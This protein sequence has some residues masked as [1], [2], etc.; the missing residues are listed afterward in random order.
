MNIRLA[1][2]FVVLPI[3]A[4]GLMPAHAQ[5]EQSTEENESS[6]DGSFG[7]LEDNLRY[8]SLM[9][10]IDGIGAN[11]GASSVCFPGMTT[12]MIDEKITEAGKADIAV[13]HLA[14][15]LV[16]ISGECS[17]DSDSNY[18]VGLIKE[19]PDRFFDLYVVGASFGA[20]KSGNCAEDKVEDLAQDLILNMRTESSDTSTVSAIRKSIERV[21]I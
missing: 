2:L 10:T 19:L 1:L 7:S 9:G 11:G 13:E 12:S 16:S 4:A 17:G 3:A 18:F 20:V 6:S 8:V 15:V 5:E 21:C 14:P